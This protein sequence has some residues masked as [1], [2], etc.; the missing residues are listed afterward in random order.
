MAGQERSEGLRSI[1]V[2]VGVLKRLAKIIAAEEAGGVED[3]DG[4]DDLVVVVAIEHGALLQHCEAKPSANPFKFTGRGRKLA[5]SLYRGGHL[6]VKGFALSAAD[7][8][9]Q[10]LL[11]P[12]R[13]LP[14]G[15][16]TLTIEN[17]HKQQR[18]TITVS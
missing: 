7:G 12:L 2:L 17:R 16:Y 13:T 1:V 4:L 8:K 9:T 15:R 3:L 10:L 18:E 5:V 14:R 6:Y 11:G